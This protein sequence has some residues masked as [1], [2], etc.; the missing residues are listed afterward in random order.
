MHA[1]D[2]A[3]HAGLNK[4]PN[5]PLLGHA[6]VVLGHLEMHVVFPTGVDDCVATRQ[7]HGHRLLHHQMPAARRHN[8]RQRVV[9]RIAGDDVHR[10]DVPVAVEHL[11]DVGVVG[12][13]EHPAG[14][15]RQRLVLIA[16]RDE[17]DAPALRQ[18]GGGGQVP[19]L[20]RTTAADNGDFRQRHVTRWAAK[21]CAC[22]FNM[23]TEPA[24]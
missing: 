21:A 3:E 18:L 20:R 15:R 8:A 7:R 4:L 17:F 11:L 9:R 5:H 24:T 10:H 16:Q 19:A 13:A 1:H 6:K 12:N 14:A 22:R 2:A 23:A